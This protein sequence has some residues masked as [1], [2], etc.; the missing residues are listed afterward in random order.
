MQI[1]KSQSTPKFLAIA[2]VFFL[3][4]VAAPLKAQDHMPWTSSLDCE[5]EIIDL[6]GRIQIKTH[7]VWRNGRLNS[8]FQVHYKGKG[9]AQNSGAEYIVKQSWNDT[10]HVDDDPK[11][12]F[13]YVYNDHAMVIG[14]GS[15]PNYEAENRL[16]IIEVDG[17]FIIESFDFYD[18][19]CELL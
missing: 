9:Y 18:G 1:L 5:G 13:I 10:Y 6:E 8:F 19:P 15:A 2:S 12:Q 3:L 7:D 4:L 17:T 11:S 14:K 16:K